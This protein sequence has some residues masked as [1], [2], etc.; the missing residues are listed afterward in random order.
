MQSSSLIKSRI[1]LAV[2]SG[3]ALVA[4]VAQADQWDKKTIVTVDQP[5]QVSDTLLEPGQ[6]VFRL[7]NSDSDRHI[8]QIFTGDQSRIVN[9]VLA[10]PN[11][12]LRPR[13]DSR[14]LFWE[15]PPGS[16]R[17]LRAWFY[18]GDNM[19]QEFRYPKQLAMLQTS[20]A[21]PAPVAPQAVIT[22]TA[23]AEAQAD[24]TPEPAPAPPPQAMNQPPSEAEKSVEIAQNATPAVPDASLEPQTTT[25]DN[26]PSTLPKTATWHPLI[27]LSGAFLLGIAALFR[28]RQ[29]A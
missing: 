23:P 22:E 28:L 8:V 20:V 27:G 11:Y 2:L 19:G 9:T 1:T 14:F 5:M 13:G 16:A 24:Q 21:A 10:I 6:Y 26:Q 25:A 7:L 3:V 29:T 12:R 15:T 18:P 17:A 4:G